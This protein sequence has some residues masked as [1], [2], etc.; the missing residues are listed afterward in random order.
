[1]SDDF[2]CI[3]GE[4]RAVSFDVQT[5][6]TGNSHVIEIGPGKYQGLHFQ[7]GFVFVDELDFRYAEGI[8]ENYVA[9]YSHWGCN[10]VPAEIGR[11]VTNDWKSGARRIPRLSPTEVIR[12]LRINDSWSN[13]ALQVVSSHGAEIAK[14]LD[15]LAVACDEFIERHGWMCILGM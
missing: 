4:D 14:M 2:L 15:D 12:E 1:M 11:L 7:P 8:L 5:S 3:F 6:F 9:D 10:D 13:E